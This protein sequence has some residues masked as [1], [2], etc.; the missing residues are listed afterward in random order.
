MIRL[1]DA[2]TVRS[3]VGFEDLVDPVRQAFADASAGRAQNGFIT[4]YPAGWEELGDVYV[5]TGATRGVPVFVVKVAPWFAVNDERGQPQGG[6]FAVLDAETGATLAVVDDQH[7]LSDVRTA[8]AGAV[9]ARELVPHHIVTA[10]VIGAGVQAF[11]QPVA[12][13]HER[14]FDRLAIWARRRAAAERLRERL[15]AALPQVQLDVS[16]GLERVV[17]EADVLLTTTSSR[18]PLVDGKWLRP[19]QH[20]TAVGA[21]DRTK[22]EL[23]PAVLQR[24]R[25]FVDALDMVAKNGNIVWAVENAGYR[26]AD[27]AGEIG[28]LVTGTLSG[29]TSPDDITVATLIGIGAQDVATADVLMERLRTG[30]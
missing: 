16:A 11:W 12:L 2:Q 19:G 9:V 3:V 24:S 7:Y 21:D 23:H 17:R 15:R 27:L 6:F 1:I 18:A 22:C 25:V 28:D 20:I 13:F 14:P 26:R 30:R 10:A 29:R 8:A 4:M 5:K